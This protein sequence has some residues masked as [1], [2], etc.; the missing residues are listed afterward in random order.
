[1][2]TGASLRAVTLS[3]TEEGWFANITR[4]IPVPAEGNRREKTAA[5]TQQLA[6]AFE[7]GIAEHP[8]DWHMLQR[9]FVA[10]LDPARLASL[11]ADSAPGAGG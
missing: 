7:K 10:D 4:D 3:F 6:R 9:V 5:M 8:Q 11:P 2:Q 1:V